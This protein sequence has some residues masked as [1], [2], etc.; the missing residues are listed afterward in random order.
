MD[1]SIEG[2]RNIYFQVEGKTIRGTLSKV[3]NQKFNATFRVNYVILTPE[4]NSWIRKFYIYFWSMG[5]PEKNG[6]IFV[7]WFN[8]HPTHANYKSSFQIA[9][10]LAVGP[11]L[12]IGDLSRT[13]VPDL[14]LV[15]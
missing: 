9:S 7:L 13:P 3:I 5:G 8:D 12:P 6:Q 11:I 1:G 2:G 4:S 14:H 10:R 15:E